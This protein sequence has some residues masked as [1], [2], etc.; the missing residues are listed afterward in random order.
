MGYVANQ[1]QT[2][3]SQEGIVL[4]MTLIPAIF[5]AIAVPLIYFYPLGDQQLEKIQQE[6]LAQQDKSNTDDGQPA[7]TGAVNV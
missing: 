6:L 2:G 3:V 4:L 5:A 1:V 7:I